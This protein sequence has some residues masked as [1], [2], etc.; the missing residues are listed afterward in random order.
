[1]SIFD[2]SCNFICWSFLPLIKSAI[3]SVVFPLSSSSVHYVSC[4]C[5]HCVLVDF[6]SIVLNCNSTEST[7]NAGKKS[8]HTDTIGNAAMWSACAVRVRWFFFCCYCVCSYPSYRYRHRHCEVR[9]CSFF[10]YY[11]CV[12][13]YLRF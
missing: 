5:A 8:A 13:F 1:M 4:S 3:H 9:W 10:A 6:H 2:F 11:V 12:L 7:M